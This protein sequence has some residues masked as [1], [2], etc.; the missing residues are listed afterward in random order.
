MWELTK[1]EENAFITKSPTSNDLQRAIALFFWG[2]SDVKEIQGARGIRLQF[3]DWGE[4]EE[5]FLLPKVRIRVYAYGK[6]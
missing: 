2:G 6:F 4:K 5:G 3:E 1:H